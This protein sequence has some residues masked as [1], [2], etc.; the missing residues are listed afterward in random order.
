MHR[1]SLVLYHTLRHSPYHPPEA[2]RPSPYTPPSFT[3]HTPSRYLCR[4]PRLRT[5]APATPWPPHSTPSKY[6]GASP[7][8]ARTPPSPRRALTPLCRAAPRGYASVPVCLRRCAAL[9]RA[10]RAYASVPVPVLEPC[11][12]AS[13]PRRAARV[14]LRA[15]TPLR[16]RGAVR[17]YTSVP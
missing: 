2:A 7:R 3:L 14:R 13:V 8:R 4:S 9:R 11:T 5:Y 17:T 1:G 12:Y 6:R 10:P 15:R 16:H